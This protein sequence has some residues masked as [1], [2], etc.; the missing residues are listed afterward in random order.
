MRKVDTRDTHVHAFSWYSWLVTHSDR[1]HNQETPLECAQRQ[2]AHSHKDVLAM[3]DEVFYKHL[4]DH[5]VEPEEAFE[6]VL[7]RKRLIHAGK[8][9][10]YEPP[11][12]GATPPGNDEADVYAPWIHNPWQ[13]YLKHRAVANS[14]IVEALASSSVCA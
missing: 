3:N 4:R 12:K 13:T 8:S 14:V 2:K 9:D 6:E 7:K 1:E 10:A 5:N 11:Q